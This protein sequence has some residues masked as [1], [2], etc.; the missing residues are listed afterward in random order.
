MPRK[1][2]LT[3]EQQE[4]LKVDIVA[5]TKQTEIAAKYDVSR[6][7]ISDVANG[8]TWK[9]VPWPE[10]Q[11]PVPKMTGGQPNELEE[12]DP[13]DE[14]ILKLD[15]QVEH[16]KAE[17]NLARRQ[18]RAA[19]KDNGVF[20]AMAEELEGRV[21]PMSALPMTLV[22]YHR[23]GK[24][25]EEHCVMHLSDGHHD[26]V[27]RPD[28]CGGLETYN[29]PISVCRGERYVDT[30]LQWTQDTLA[31]RFRFPVL[32]V[33]AY[34]D[35]T[36]GEIHGAAERSYYRNQFK[37]C[38]AIGEL[39][40]LMLRDLAPHFEKVNV[41]YLA[42]NHGRRSH[43]KDYHGAQNNWDYLVA[44][45]SQLYCRDMK[46][47]DI[48]IPNCWSVN[49]D[50][51]GVGFNVGHGDDVRSNAGTPWYGLQRRQRNMTALAHLGTGPRVR[52]YCVGHFHRS[53][54]VADVDGE[55]LV[56]GAWPATDAYAYE[57]LAAYTEPSQWLHGVNP[58]YGISW[59]MACKL[60]DIER[61][62]LGP[63]RYQIEVD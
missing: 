59:R 32:N 23:Q 42:G 18:A 49:L 29:F 16:L 37:N 47:V 4:A 60:K 25:V 63:Q 15:A 39:H 22:P 43:K 9:T 7:L 24:V 27:V 2:R 13:T 8:R 14:R 58:K 17:R 31:D 38:G 30:V 46:N 40:A 52:Y 6:S 53:G 51:N 48:L 45:F 50:I 3:P 61:E 62:A 55:L 28:E 34:G 26:Q 21:Y 57:S 12:F 19:A 10:G 44:K 11:K 33:L 1:S 41:V 54:A 56:N 20:Q 35:F 36:S 5:G